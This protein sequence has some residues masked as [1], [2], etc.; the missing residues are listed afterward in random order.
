MGAYLLPG[1]PDR[2]HS[3]PRAVRDNTLRF[4]VFNAFESFNPVTSLNTGATFIFPLVFS[5]L[6]G[7]GKN[8][9]LQPELAES[10]QYDSERHIW[11]LKLREDALF[12]DGMPVTAADVVFSIDEGLRRDNPSAYEQIKKITG[13]SRFSLDITLKYDDPDFFSRVM[14]MGILPSHLPLASHERHPV[15]CGPFQFIESIDNQQVI[16]KAFDR[17]YY[18]RPAIDRVEFHFIPDKEQSW[19]RLLNN[20]TDIAPLISP[21]NFEMLS[22]LKNRYRISE[23]LSHT[24]WSVLFNTHAP[25]LSDPRVRRALALGIDRAH[26]VDTVL[27]GHGRVADDFYGQ[28]TGTGTPEIPPPSY[29]PVKGRTLLEAAG[30]MR[31]ET[32][33]LFYRTGKP[34]EITMIYP[35]ESPVEKQVAELIKLFLYDL[36]VKVLLSPVT[37]DYLKDAMHFNNDFQSVLTEIVPLS[38]NPLKTIRSLVPDK[39][40]CAEWGCFDDDRVTRLYWETFR[41]TNPDRRNQKI[42][43]LICLLYDLQP[44]IELFHKTDFD[45][46][47]KRVQ[48]RHPRMS[49]LF[50]VHHLYDATLLN[51]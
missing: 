34:F 25:L 27:M 21:R 15:G 22:H 41:E 8:G 33:G 38:F 36:G 46:I 48:T 6:A 4:D 29:D 35:V 44:S 40:E 24:C 49:Y 28:E 39:D 11:H 17:F 2:A 5:F 47:S 7:P 16:L 23:N 51:R 14:S 18:G 1:D 12:H 45:L 19:A 32:N 30:W 43:E 3:R 10:W 13:L 20:E 50:H 31:N 26:I 42:H 37:H 9:E